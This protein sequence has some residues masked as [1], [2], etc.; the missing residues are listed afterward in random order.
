MDSGELVLVGA[1]ADGSAAAEET[2]DLTIS[3]AAGIA[4]FVSASPDLVPG[5]T[6]GTQD[7]FVKDLATGAIEL[8]RP[9]GVV[10]DLHIR[11]SFGDAGFRR[12]LFFRRAFQIIQHGV[13][14]GA[15]HDGDIIGIT[16]DEVTGLNNIAAD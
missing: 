8:V 4:A 11:L 14:L 5:D 7:V 10:G 6:A 2:T 13:D 1:A 15:L 12:F 9:A 3:S 16:D